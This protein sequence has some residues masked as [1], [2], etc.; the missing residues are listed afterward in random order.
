MSSDGSLSIS[1]DWLGGE[2]VAVNPA[3]TSQTCSACGHTDKANRKT[4]AKFECVA[5]GH[6]ENAD[7]Q[8]AKNI[9]ALG[10]SVLACGE[11]S[12]EPSKKQELQQNREKVAA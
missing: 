6:S 10:H 11:G 12:L 5:C 9:L 1:R 7:V 2:V 4:Q 3:Y 8:A